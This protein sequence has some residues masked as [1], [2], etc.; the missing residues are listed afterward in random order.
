V[1]TSDT[2]TIRAKYERHYGRYASDLTDAER[3]LG[4]PFLPPAKRTGRPRSTPVRDVLG[5]VLYIANTGCPWRMLAASTGFDLTVPL[6][7][8]PLPDP[9]QAWF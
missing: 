2:E 4:T 7:T 3:E 8:I 6:A 1:L 5:A 9:D